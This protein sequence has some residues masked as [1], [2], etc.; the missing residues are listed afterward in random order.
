MIGH[1]MYNYIQDGQ[2]SGWEVYYY[3]N[4]TN[5]TYF[6]LFCDLYNNVSDFILLYIG[7]E[8]V[9]LVALEC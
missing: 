3:S 9:A 4:S 8:H 6:F 7:V 5:Q 1:Y 2:S